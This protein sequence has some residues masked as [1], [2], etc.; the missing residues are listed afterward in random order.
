MLH[1]NIFDKNSFILYLIGV[2]IA[3]AL[4]TASIYLC[5]GRIITI[6]SVELSWLKPRTITCVFVAFDFLSLVLQAAGGAMASTSDEGDSSNQTGINTLIGGLAVQVVSLV[7]FSAVGLHFAWNVYKNP[8]KL[9][10]MYAG[11]RNSRR[12]KAFL[13]GTFTIP[14]F[15]HTSLISSSNI[16]QQSHSPP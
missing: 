8:S 6:F 5:L 4:V 1:H 3:P 13:F 10:P 7:L 9:N 12:W 15:P 11:L 14:H 2:T 16:S